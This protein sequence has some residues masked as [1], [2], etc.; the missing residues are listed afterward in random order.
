[1]SECVRE[2]SL[3]V[4]SALFLKVSSLPKASDDVD[5]RGLQLVRMRRG[6][7]CSL[8]VPEWRHADSI[9][10]GSSFPEQAKYLLKHVVHFHPSALYRL[11]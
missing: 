5:E 11:H 8:Q 3:H 10:A 1:M 7:R 2:I 4:I 6:T 9:W